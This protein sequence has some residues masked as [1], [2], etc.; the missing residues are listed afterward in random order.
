M[1]KHCECFLLGMST[2]FVILVIVED[3]KAGV[4]VSMCN[5]GACFVSSGEMAY[6][7]LF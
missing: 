5:M 6:P 7:G 2:K 3:L 4:N 1:Y